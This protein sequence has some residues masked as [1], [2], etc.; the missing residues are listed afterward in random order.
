M[1]SIHKTFFI[2]EKIV[3]DD[4]SEYTRI[5][6][7]FQIKFILVLICLS[8]FACEDSN[9]DQIKITDF[10]TPPTEIKDQ[11]VVIVQP[12]SVDMQIMDMRPVVV[13]D[14]MQMEIEDMMSMEP[15]ACTQGEIRLL[16]G[17]GYEKCESTGNWVSPNPKREYCNGHDDDCDQKTDE[18]FNI[19]G[20]CSI[21]ND[22]MCT[23]KGTLA[24]QNGQAQ[25]MVEGTGMD[26]E[27]CDGIDNDCDRNI[28]EGFPSDPKCCSESIHCPS[29][30]RCVDHLCKVPD[31]NIGGTMTGGSMSGGSTAGSMGG[32]QQPNVQGVGTCASPI[33]LMGFGEFIADGSMA[34]KKATISDCTGTADDDLIAL[35]TLLGSEMIFSFRFPQAQR[36]TVSSSWTPFDVVLSVGQ[37]SDN[38]LSLTD[39]TSLACDEAEP[40]ALSPAEVTVDVMANTTY[41]IVLDTTLNIA[42]LSALFGTDLGYL[43]FVISL[44]PASN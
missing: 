16:N 2:F 29:G 28:D 20:F 43:P 21:L 13:V 24:C 14:M 39:V 18:N 27:S 5:S 12:P 23:L 37:C 44:Q 36:V 22:Q 40:T 11:S 30:Q 31:P 7:M 34:Q 10:Y 25:C 32:N 4:Q 17:C 42:E 41:Y 26:A 35:Q 6:K 3:I 9:L 33:Q 19:G 15:M 38:F 8:F 1:D